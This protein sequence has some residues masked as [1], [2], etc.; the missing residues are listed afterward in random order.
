MKGRTMP[1]PA[2]LYR[3]K[4]TVYAE[5]EALSEEQARELAFQ[6]VERH[7]SMDVNDVV[8]EPKHDGSVN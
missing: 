4:V 7:T 3:F 2:P 8:V 5:I 6:Q 1:Q